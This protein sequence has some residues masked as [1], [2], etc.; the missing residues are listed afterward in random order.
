[1]SWCPAWSRN[2]KPQAMLRNGVLV[3]DRIKSRSKCPSSPSVPPPP[4]PPL[5]IQEGQNAP[6][7]HLWLEEG[8]Y[9]GGGEFSIYFCPILT[10]TSKWFALQ[11]EWPNM[12]RSPD[13]N[14]E[15]MSAKNRRLV[16]NARNL[17]GVAFHRQFSRPQYWGGKQVNPNPIPRGTSFSLRKE[18]SEMSD[19][20][21][22]YYFNNG[23]LTFTFA[24]LS[25]F[26]LS[27]E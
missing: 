6:F 3:L 4:P 14:R 24:Y 27:A 17:L 25:L 10:S 15:K 21:K 5:W 7:S 11:C 23:A 26:G 20:D 16:C 9:Q 22:A 19:N 1:M 18:H 2:R 12:N 13:R 8:G